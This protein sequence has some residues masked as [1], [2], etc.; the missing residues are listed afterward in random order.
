MSRRVAMVV[1]PRFQILDATGPLAALEIASH[2]AGEAYDIHLLAETAG[3]VASSAG[4]SLAAETLDERRYD[5]VI[6]S[7]GDGTRALA[8]HHAVVRWLQRQA[9]TARRMAS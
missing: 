5:T 7:G 4:V 8:D 1:F 9:L 6:V 3:M 2:V